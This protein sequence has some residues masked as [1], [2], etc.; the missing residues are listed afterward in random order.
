MEIFDTH[1]DFMTKIK[2]DKNKTKYLCSKKCNNLNAVIGGIWTTEMKCEQ[3]VDTVEKC[4]DFAYQYNDMVLDNMDSQYPNPKLKVQ[5]VL[6]GIEDM[7]FVNSAN[8]LRVINA[9]PAYCGLTWNYDNHLAGGAHENGLLTPFGIEVIEQ[10]ENNN[11]QID[12]AHLNEKSFMAVSKLTTR[13]LFCSHTAVRSLVNNPRNLKDYQL[14]MVQESC[15]LVGIAL[16]GS[17]LSE[18]KKSYIN[19][20][21]RHIDYVASRFSAECVCLGTDFYGTRN[22]PKG[23]KN[24][25]DMSALENRLRLMGF[26][27]QTIEMIFYKNAQNF[28][29]M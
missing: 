1:N 6:L 11:I 9:H 14:K 8:I 17:F 24:Y 15:G 10:L 28:F 7:N 22:L 19:D 5:K 3:A 12:T 27:S 20:I 2:G 26:D 29:H 21:A 23:I 25:G 18:G 13:P 4:F 16:V